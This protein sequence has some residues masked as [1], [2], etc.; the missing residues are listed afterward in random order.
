MGPVLRNQLD[1]EI[2]DEVSMAIPL[3]MAEEEPR[4]R[5]VRVAAFNEEAMGSVA[6]MR[7]EEVWRLFRND[8]ELPSNAVSGVVVRATDRGMAEVRDR[9]L[10]LPHAGSVL[11]IP[12]IRTLVARMLETFRTFVWI[13][14]FFGVAL[15]LAMI[16]NM[17]TINVLERTSE[18]ATL[19]TLGVSRHQVS[20]MIGTENLVVALIGIVIGLPFSR[21]FIEQFW[22]AAQ[23][24]EQQ[25]LFTFKVAVRLETFLLA[26]LAIMMAVLLSQ[27]PALRLLNRL[28]LVKAT[29]ERGAS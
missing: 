23:T 29:K 24:E 25:Q 14:E 12:E 28:D 7:R 19:R 18:I 20:M 2:G 10:N 6:Y 17:V 9:L 22:K 4:I 8:L 5:R 13:M 1:L 16:F 3:Q 27:L 11:S 21:W 15:A 26:V